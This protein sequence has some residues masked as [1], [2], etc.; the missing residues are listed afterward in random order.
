MIAGIKI[1]NRQAAWTKTQR[2]QF[3]MGAGPWPG[4]R[5]WPNLLGTAGKLY[6]DLLSTFKNDTRILMWDLYNE[7]GNG[8]NFDKSLHF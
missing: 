6:Q 2:P 3:R 5:Q 8:D 7:P 1:L 4:P